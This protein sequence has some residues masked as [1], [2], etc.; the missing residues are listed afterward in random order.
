[1]KDYSEDYLEGVLIGLKICKGMWVQGTISY[2]NIYENEV[3]Y[4][5]LLNEK[6]FDSLE[7]SGLD[8]PFDLTQDKF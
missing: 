6:V 2:E 7:N 8:K 5:E 4:G 3:Y 1:M